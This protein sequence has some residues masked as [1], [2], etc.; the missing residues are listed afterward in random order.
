[1]TSVT[2]TVDAHILPGSSGK[3]VDSGGPQA[4]TSVYLQKRISGGVRSGERGVRV[5]RLS[6]PIN[7]C[8]I[9]DRS[10]QL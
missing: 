7:F 6:L 9:S 4:A 1:M 3:V 5:V 8:G 10:P 2:V